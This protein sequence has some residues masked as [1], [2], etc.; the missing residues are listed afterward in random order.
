MRAASVALFWVARSRAGVAWESASWLAEWESSFC[1]RRLHQFCQTDNLMH[2]L[3]LSTNLSNSGKKGLYWHSSPQLLSSLAKFGP[4]RRCVDRLGHFGRR[5]RSCGTFCGL[6][7]RWTLECCHQGFLTL[8]SRA[9]VP[10]ASCFATSGP[11]D[12]RIVWN[13]CQHLATRLQSCCDLVSL[14]NEGSFMAEH[15]LVLRRSQFQPWLSPPWRHW[16]C[17]SSL[18]QAQINPYPQFGCCASWLLATYLN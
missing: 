17:R 18:V 4:E 1:T 5:E 3:N 13:S 2:R 16:R 9:R 11:L 15:P 14:C 10:Q 12:H 7:V 8:L 6:S